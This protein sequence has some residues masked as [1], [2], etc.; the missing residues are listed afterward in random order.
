MN[1][2]GFRLPEAEPFFKGTCL[3]LTSLVPLSSGSG[4]GGRRWLCA[5]LESAEPMASTGTRTDGGRP[6]ERTGDVRPRTPE[7]PLKRLCRDTSWKVQR[8][9]MISR[10]LTCRSFPMSWEAKRL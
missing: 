10:E 4:A 5:S 6:S 1:F 3:D 2:M 7:S 9:E 8:I